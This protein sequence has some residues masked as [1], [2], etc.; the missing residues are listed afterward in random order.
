MKKK[1]EKST[2]V[3]LAIFIGVMA[4]WVGIS[5]YKR[6]YDYSIYDVNYELIELRD[7][8]YK[9]KLSEDDTKNIA[10]YSNGCSREYNENAIEEDFIPKPRAELSEETKDLIRKSIANHLSDKSRKIIKAEDIELGSS[11][12]EYNG[13]IVVRRL[14]ESDFPAENL[15]TL[16]KVKVRE[17]CD[18]K[19]YLWKKL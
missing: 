12:G 9:G 14:F 16:G 11:Y 5:E 6:T 2:I 18:E 8:Y 19:I 15:I 1:I 3:T 17:S 10:Y 4:I 13:Y 7:A